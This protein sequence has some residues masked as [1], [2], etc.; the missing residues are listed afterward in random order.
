MQALRSSGGAFSSNHYSMA[1][2]QSEGNVFLIT[3]VCV[4]GLEISNNVG[5]KTALVSV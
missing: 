5:M 2:V 3:I 4:C 1:E